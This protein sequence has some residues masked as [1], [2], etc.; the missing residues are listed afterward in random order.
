MNI[1]RENIDELNA[2]LKIQVTAED[3]SEKV[4]TV[5]KDY[6][7]KARIDGFRPGKV[8]FGMIKKMYGKAVLIEEVNKI[9]LDGINSHIREE[10][11]NILGEPLPKEDEQVNIDWD[12]QTDFEFAFELGLAPNIEIKLSKRDKINYYKIAI[13]EEMRSSFIDNQ[14][15]RLGEFIITD[16]IEGTEMVKGKLEQ[17]DAEGAVLEGGAAT[18][19]ATIS[20][21][22]IKD[23]DITKQFVGG[24]VEDIIDFDLKKAFPNDSEI[25]AML[26]VDKDQVADIEGNF[27]FTIA[28]IKRFV[29]AEINQEF[30]DK[31]YGEGV[32][33]SEEEHHAKV[34]E[35]ISQ[36]LSKDSDYKLAIDV[37]EK[38][39]K[40]FKFDL[41]EEF[42]KRWL[43]MV[44][45]GKFTKEQIDEEFPLFADDMKWQLIKDTIIKEKEIKVEEKDVLELAKEM[46]A[47][48]FAYYGMM[49]LTDEQLEQYSKEILK[50][51]EEVKKMYER[52]YEDKVNATVKDLIKVEEK[53]ISKEEFGKFFEKK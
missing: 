39:V 51:K 14:T 21:D 12:N 13:D 42:L 26:R 23:E 18:D 49:N 27:R 9:I 19:E 35:E 2:V 29:S 3:Y 1:S 32:V 36:N 43:L 20:V 28:E 46:T 11:L 5:L 48:Q 45:E 4:S 37:K 40:K 31:L 16:T 52:I 53:E 50:N 34:D 41:P 44:N 10:K 22:T 30:Y 8:P 47:Q 6:T 38:L 7:K 17:L 25:A 15:R 24:K 33:N